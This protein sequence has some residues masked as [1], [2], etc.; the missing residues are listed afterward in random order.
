MSPKETLERVRRKAAPAPEG[1]VATQADDPV[2]QIRRAATTD[3]IS[4]QPLRGNLGLITGAGGNVVVLADPDGVLLVDTAIDG[5][6]VEAT[7]A[8]LTHAPIR[9]LVNTHWHFDHTDGNEWLGRHG[10][11][12]IAHENTRRHLSQATRVEDY[13]VTFPPVS[14]AALPRLLFTD[15]LIL[16]VGHAG[17]RLRHYAPGHTDSDIS[18]RFDDEDVLQVADTWWNGFYP[19]I[20]YSTGGSIDGLIAAAEWNLAAASGDTL[21]VPGHGAAG[22]RAQLQAYYDMLID[23]REEVVE[24]KTRGFTL[25]ETVRTRPTRAFDETWGHGLVDP[26][27]FTRLVYRGV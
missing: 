19:F 8:S 13:G 18:V 23:V 27:F 12:L 3:P 24:L 4:V 21:I 10:A 15:E 6:R 20:D 17:V 25:D 1:G 16:A 26:A 5:P 7:V 2:V 9:Y 14:A 22:D 11:D